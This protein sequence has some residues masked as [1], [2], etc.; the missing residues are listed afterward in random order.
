MPLQREKKVTWMLGVL[1]QLSGAGR[2][3]Y[4]DELRAFVLCG[5][6]PWSL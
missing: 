3:V 6:K 1:W 4:E 2:F 5:V